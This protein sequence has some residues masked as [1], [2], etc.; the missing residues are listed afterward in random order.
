MAGLNSVMVVVTVVASF[1]CCY[2]N[3]LAEHW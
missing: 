3:S 2:R 1:G